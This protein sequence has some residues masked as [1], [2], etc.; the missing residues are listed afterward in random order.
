VIEVMVTVTIF[1]DEYDT[2]RQKQLEKYGITFL[3]FSDLEIKNNLFNVLNTIEI[4]VIKLQKL[5]P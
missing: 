4:K 3:R 5:S 2:K 1:K